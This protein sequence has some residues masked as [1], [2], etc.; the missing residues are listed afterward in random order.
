LSIDLAQA[1]ISVILCTKDKAKAV[2]DIVDKLP[3]VKTLIVMDGVSEELT[4]QAKT[5]SIAII[6]QDEAE[7]WGK[8][9]PKVYTLF[10]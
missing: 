9:N 8:E 10:F 3:S 6:G 1:A 7:A 4:A 2:L 5:A